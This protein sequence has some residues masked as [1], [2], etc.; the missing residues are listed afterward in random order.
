MKT[1][2]ETAF[3]V[4]SRMEISD[5]GTQFCMTSQFG[6]LNLKQILAVFLVLQP[7]PL[8]V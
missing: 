5:L 4:Y 6:A 2:K 8:V 3:Y 1:H 7:F